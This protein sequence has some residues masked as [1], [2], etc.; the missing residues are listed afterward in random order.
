H[1]PPHEPFISAVQVPWHVPSHF[2][3]A[4]MSHVPLHCA[5]H[6]PERCPRSHSTFASPGFT[7][8]SHL[9]AP[10]VM[11]CIDAWHSGGLMSSVSFAFAPTFAFASCM[12]LSAALQASSPL[13]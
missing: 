4:F 10:S 3:A 1:F 12:P 11:A 8:A 9:P 2:A 13:L 6:E 5:S 7:V